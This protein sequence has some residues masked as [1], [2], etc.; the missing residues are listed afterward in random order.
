MSIRIEFH[1]EDFKYRHLPCMVEDGKGNYY[2]WH[3]M[4]SLGARWCSERSN[5]VIVRT[6]RAWLVGLWCRR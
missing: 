1:V 6:I 4:N 2:M 5:M 3:S